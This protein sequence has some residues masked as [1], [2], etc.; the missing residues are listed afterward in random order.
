MNM[1]RNRLRRLQGKS[2]DA[3]PA[4]H[5]EDRAASSQS[6]SQQADKPVEAHSV[7]QAECEPTIGHSGTGIDNDTLERSANSTAHSSE[8]APAEQA[9][10]AG[11]SAASLP[12]LQLSA[13]PA[14]EPFAEKW[15]ELSVQLAQNEFGSFLLRS[16]RACG[17][18][19][20]GMHAFGEWQQASS[21]LNAFHP[22][23][24]ADPTQFLFLDLETTGLGSGTGNVP[25]MVGLAFWENDGFTVQQALIRHPAEERA[26]LAYVH[27]LTARFTHLVTYNGKSFDWPLMHSR[28]VLNGMRQTIWE[29]LHIDLLHP[30]RAIWRNTLES[31]KLSHIEKMR[32]G[33]V[34]IDDL[35]GAEAPA[36]YFQYLNSG[37]PGLLEDVYR[38]N[39]IDMLSLVTLAIRFGHL[40]SNRDV[41]SIVQQPNE[42]EE[43]VRTGLWLERM[44]CQLYSEQLFQLAVH[45]PQQRTQTLML[46]AMRDK[47]M[48]N[49]ERA[50]QLWQRVVDTESI[51]TTH[52]Q[53]EAAIELSMYYEHKAKQLEQALAYAETAYE[54]LRE[55]RPGGRRSAQQQQKELEQLEKRLNRLKKKC[56]G[57][58]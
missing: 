35:P 26:M 57:T 47:R 32:L 27:R 33:I 21:F 54:R 49:M 4:D 1:L 10:A 51:W 25:F 38:H 17:T 16:L 12:Q 3:Q 55:I 7:N 41:K 48:Q 50:L 2:V 36:R 53:V 23:S 58:A 56:R 40:L 44:G 18:A 15:A 37:D 42:P 43:M 28:Y 46:L 30:S 45:V 5:A 19:A 24:S 52:D 9:I 11:S 6:D 8:T 20:I 22:Q 29:P 14:A 39:E 34:R 31:C 13:L